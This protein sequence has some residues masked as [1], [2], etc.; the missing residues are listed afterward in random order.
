MTMT[1]TP[2]LR[3]RPS[4]ERQPQPTLRPSHADVIEN[5]ERWANSAGLQPPKLEAQK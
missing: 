3:R 5:L 2:K 1:E 4:D